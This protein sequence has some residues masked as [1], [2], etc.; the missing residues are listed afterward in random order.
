M[1]TIPML[2]ARHGAQ[3]VRARPARQRRRGVLR[4]QRAA[5][6]RHRQGD[7]GLDPVPQRVRHAVGWASSRDD[8]R[9]PDRP[10]RQHQ[11]RQHRAVVNNPKAQL[12]GVRGGPGNTI[13]HATSFF[14]PKH[15]TTVFASAVDMVSGIG[16][17]RAD[18]LGPWVRAHHD[19]PPG[20][21]QP[22]GARLR[23]R[24]S[25]D[26]PASVFTPA[27]RSPTC[28][29]AT[30]FELVIDDD[31]PISRAPTGRRARR[32][33]PPRPAGA[34]PSRGLP[35]RRD[36]A[37]APAHAAVRSVRHRRADRADGHGLGCGSSPRV[38]HRQRRRR[39]ASSPAR[40]WTSPSCGRR[41]PR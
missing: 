14:I 23:M 28:Q 33:R 29:A 1:G 32:D 24:R 27:C 40:R 36:D 18:A 25:L 3:H 6:R 4:R 35:T 8:G 30:G 5:D 39:S 41:S 11:H 22:G 19:L 38:G 15:T 16:Y 2:G 34:A 10:L 37:S 17:D 12:L 21:H 9:Q 26:A 7:R 20:G 13:S 31:V